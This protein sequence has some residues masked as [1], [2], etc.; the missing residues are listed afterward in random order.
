ML[1]KLKIWQLKFPNLP[2]GAT[3]NK[4][5]IVFIT[6]VASMVSTLVYA[7]PGEYWEI[8]V[9]SDMAGMP[10]G[11]TPFTMKQCMPNDRNYFLDK[12]N[13]QDKDCKLSNIKKSANNASFDITC[14]HDGEIM[15]GHGEFTLHGDTEEG[16]SHMS[17]KIQGHDMNI[18]QKTKG[19]RI[20]GS[21]DTETEAKEM[22]AANDRN[23]ARKAQMDQMMQ[24]QKAYM[25]ESCT[26]LEKNYEW[27]G[28]PHM[29]FGD[30]PM[31][32]SN[33]AKLCEALRKD[34]T[35]DVKVYEKVIYSEQLQGKQI[36][37]VKECKIDMAAT[38]KSIC[39]T[40]MDNGNYETLSRYCPAEAK[41]FREVQ[42]KKN[43]EGRV[44]TGM[45]A[46]EG[47]KRCMSGDEG[48]N[49]SGSSDSGNANS[50]EKPAKDG[51]SDVLDT[52]TKLLKGHFG[53]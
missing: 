47:I 21:C 15:N 51:T 42:R 9:T 18:T 31:C 52:A 48:G 36:S 22:A 23:I 2:N 37:V 38:T 24:N 20:G 1:E 11:A 41:A 26:S 40:P 5:L 30:Q 13:K 4:Y 8:T 32:K 17:G 35:K 44:Y 43:C 16:T 6:L 34:I 49:S 29:F 27:V 25:D 39:K 7:V 53:F 14:N 33:T 10:S 45:P 50:T 28:A 19:K 46:A 12:M 3:M